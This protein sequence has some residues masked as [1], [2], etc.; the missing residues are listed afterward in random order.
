MSILGAIACGHPQTA[1]AAEEILLDGGNSFDAIIA[2]MLMACV[3]EPVLASLGGGGFLL[4]QA[5]GAAPRIYDFFPQTPLRRAADQEFYPIEANFGTATQTFHIGLGSAAVPGSVAGIF[6]VHEAL[7][8]LPMARLAEPAVNAAR[9]GIII[10][11]FQGYIFDIVRPIYQANTTTARAYAS[12]VTGARLHQSDLASSLGAIARDGAASFYTGE[13]AAEISKTSHLHGGHLTQEDLANYAVVVREPFEFDYRGTR[14]LTNPPPSAGGV[15]IALT[16][17][18]LEALDLSE[19]VPGSA[20]HLGLLCNAMSLTSAAR[21]DNAS[22]FN[23]LVRTYQEKIVT[24][25]QFSRGTTHISV[26]DDKGNSAALTLSNGEGCGHLVAGTGIMLNNMLGEEDI[27]PDGVGNWPVN[28]RLGSMMAPTLLEHGA[29]R[30]ALGSGGSN[31]IR[32]AITQVISQLLDFAQ[33]P[34]AA[35]NFPR[36]HLEAEL[37]SVEAGFD[38]TTATAANRGV[39]ARTEVLGR[40]ELRLQEWDSPNL[41]FGGVHLAGLR[42]GVFQAA[43]DP[44]RG[45]SGTLVSR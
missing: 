41:F 22:G 11:D 25:A 27:N 38:T 35:V 6:A 17:K 33:A 4:A 13:I 24:A 20:E 18:L 39:H 5:Q 30:Y 23:E 12:A 36:A 9:N 26:I 19:V 28:V 44:R 43:G 40:A 34:A 45:G 1:A 3:T 14:V 42:D 32:S 31:R 8:T 37:L 15:L 10:N 16:L 2:A 7:V 29:T 21:T